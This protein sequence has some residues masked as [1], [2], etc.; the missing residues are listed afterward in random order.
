[1]KKVI[2]LL[3]VFALCLPLCACGGEKSIS[4]GETYR[5]GEISFKVS[6]IRYAPKITFIKYV[7][8]QWDSSFDFD[9]I[10]QPTTGTLGGRDRIAGSGKTFM[11][12][13]FEVKSNGQEELKYNDFE[14]K[15][16]FSG[17]KTFDV[18]GEY[19]EGDSN[20]IGWNCREG[21]SLEWYEGHQ[22]R[23]YA[24]CYTQVQTDTSAKVWLDVKI[25]GESFKVNIR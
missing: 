17:K 23:S 8:S 4:V 15:L 24:E 2:C 12:I 9:G 19:Y 20:T 13:D 18:Y 6:Q 7:G 1:M 14:M 11:I 3:L 22:Y 21:V 5:V 10:L 25:N 16:N